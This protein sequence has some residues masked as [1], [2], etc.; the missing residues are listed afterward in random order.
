MSKLIQK[1]IKA[2][3]TGLTDDQEREIREAFDLFDTNRQSSIDYYEAR[4]CM[5]ALGFDVPHSEMKQ[6][7]AYYDKQKT[8]RLS[9]E[10]FH[11]VLT[12]KIQQR[13][14]VE[15]MIKAFQLFDDD[16]TGKVTLKNLKR[17]ARD[18]GENIS[19]EELL[20]MINE[21]DRDGDGELD[22]EDFIAIL[23]SSE[24]FQ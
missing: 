6:I 17:V 10:Q 22:Q 7:M 16:N 1:T 4:V 9:F 15:E 5:R 8:N 11:E 23:K 21:F 18:L 14:P 2:K 3:R 13:D 19:D 24:A 20:A 12:E